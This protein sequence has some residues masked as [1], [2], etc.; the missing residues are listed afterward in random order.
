[1]QVQTVDLKLLRVFETIIQCGGFALAQ[2]A[3]GL[4]SSR[5]SEYMSQL[6]TRMGVRL[7]ERGRGGFRLTEDG[8]HLHEAAQRLLGA[9]ETFRVESDSLGKQM[10]GVLRFGMVEAT[11]SDA[12][13]PVV[14]AIRS[15]V[16]VAPDIRLHVVIDTTAGMEHRVLDG[17]LDLAMGPFPGRNSALHYKMLYREEQMLYCGPHHPLYSCPPG[18]AQSEEIR[19]SKLVARAYLGGAETTILKIPAAAAT[20]DNVEGR[21]MLIL[22]GSYIGFLPSHYA[23]PLEREGLLKRVNPDRLQTRLEFKIIRRRGRQ[24][25]RTVQTFLDSLIAASKQR[26]TTNAL[27]RVPA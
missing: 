11:L 3:L 16:A 18:A 9:V 20:A 8:I 17:S 4:S 2:S 13:C 14:A 12:G 23:N 19:R 7:C 26:E 24:V 21:A 1:M 10:R 15:F 6:E 27:S 22:S 25:P 5:I